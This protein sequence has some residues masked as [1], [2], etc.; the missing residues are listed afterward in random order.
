MNAYQ[1]LNQQPAR[2][3]EVTGWAR[4]ANLTHREHFKR[5]GI[6]S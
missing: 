1:L 6:Q 5:N 4:H 3:A 2:N